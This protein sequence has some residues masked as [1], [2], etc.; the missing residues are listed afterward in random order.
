MFGIVSYY[1]TIQDNIVLSSI[2]Y[3]NIGLIAAPCSEA[4]ETGW[5]GL[6]FRGSCQPYDL[7]ALITKKPNHLECFLA[8]VVSVGRPV[9]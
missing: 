7:W 8:L 1:S 6:L 3:N 5:R 4:P 9:S 2:S